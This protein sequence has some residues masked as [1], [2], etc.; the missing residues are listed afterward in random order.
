MYYKSRVCPVCG[1]VIYYNLQSSFSHANKRNSKC[2]KCRTEEIKNPVKNGFYGK[3]HTEETKRKI[4]AKDHSYKKTERF[5]QSVKDGYRG[6]AN[7]K[8]HYDCWV[9]KYGKEEAEKRHAEESKKKS[10]N[11]KGKNNPMYGKPAP[12]GSGNGWKGWYIGTFF[13]SL[14]ELTWMIKSD[15]NGISWRVAEKSTDAIAYTDP[16]G[17]ERNYYPDFRT[18]N[19]L[20]E[21]KPNKLSDTPSVKSK[22]LAA[23]EWCKNNGLTYEIVDP[24]IIDS[25]RLFELIDNGSVEI[26]EKYKDRVNEYRE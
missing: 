12:Q 4:S 13:R 3:K 21:C 6:N 2:K 14:R 5:S 11:S 18:D 15:D 24:G 22:R 17:I 25:K 10:E 1:D 9:E 16:M 23:I 20:I 19:A 26:M 8:S 7:R